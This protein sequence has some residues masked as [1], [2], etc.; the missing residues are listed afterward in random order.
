[1]SENSGAPHPLHYFV[2]LIFGSCYSTGFMVYLPVFDSVLFV[3]HNCWK[4]L[5]HK[6][7]WQVDKHPLRNADMMLGSPKCIY[8]TIFK[9][10]LVHQTQPTMYKRSCTS[11]QSR[12]IP[13]KQGWFSIA[14]SKEYISRVYY[15]LGLLFTGAIS[16]CLRT[17]LCGKEYSCAPFTDE[18]RGFV[19]I[20]RPGMLGCLWQ[21]LIWTQTSCPSNLVQRCRHHPPAPPP[22]LS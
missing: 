4:A 13:S 6:L 11:K 12:F 9:K 20:T 21:G 19:Y 2:L 22:N 10:S 7:K 16:F 14:D 18:K 1:M 15:P 3:A 8:A 17:T 5:A